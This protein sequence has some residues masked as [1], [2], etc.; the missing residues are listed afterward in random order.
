VTPDIAERVGVHASV[1]AGLARE[2]D[3]CYFD[4]QH[5]ADTQHLRIPHGPTARQWGEEQCAVLASDITLHCEKLMQ[6]VE[7]G[8]VA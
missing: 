4:P 3:E 5:Y 7:P 6:L 2:Y 8:R 1:V